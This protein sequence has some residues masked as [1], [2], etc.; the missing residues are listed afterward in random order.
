MT[1]PDRIS[2]GRPPTPAPAPVPGRDWAY[3]FDIDGTLVDIAESPA[4]IDLDPALRQLLGELFQSVGGA[5][6]LITGRS[7]AD[8]DSLFPAPHLPAAGQHGVERRDAGGQMSRHPFPSAPLDGARRRLAEAVTRRPGLMLEDKGM[9]LA[10]HYRQV[11]RL[12]GYAHRLMHAVRSEL[13]EE[14]AVQGGKRVVELKPAGQ[15]KGAAILEFMQ[16]D[17]FRGRTPVFVGDDMTDEFGFAMVNRLGGHSVKVGLGRTA[18]SWRLP[19]VSS[20]LAWLRSG[21]PLPR[22][23]GGRSVEAAR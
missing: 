13:G 14:F 21:R 11:P 19:D 1:M 12:A 10:L 17:P 4:G 8:I 9:S 18:A 5:M 15:D 22:P 7:I 16:E 20:V 2:P 6:A 23:A 3:F